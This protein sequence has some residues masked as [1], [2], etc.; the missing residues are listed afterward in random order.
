MTDTS[1]VVPGDSGPRRPLAEQ[2]RMQRALKAL[3][4]VS[5]LLLADCS[6]F[7]IRVPSYSLH[8]VDPMDEDLEPLI[9]RRLRRLESRVPR[10][11]FRVQ[12]P[13]GSLVCSQS[14]RLGAPNPSTAPVAP[15]PP[16]LCEVR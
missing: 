12:T 9:P 3:I 11:E 5:G 15:I 8:Q 6:S 4:A 16:T 7:V 2:V 1:L 13:G 10:F 14:F